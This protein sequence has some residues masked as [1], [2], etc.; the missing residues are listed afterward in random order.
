M[1][2]LYEGVGGARAA[3]GGDGSNGSDGCG[4]D[5]R[6]QPASAASSAAAEIQYH[7]KIFSGGTAHK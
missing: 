3:L 4:I 5:D 2:L 1:T 7:L 6:T